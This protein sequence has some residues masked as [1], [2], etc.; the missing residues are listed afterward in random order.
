[1]RLTGGVLPADLDLVAWV[2]AEE[3][4]AEL[5]AGGDGL[6]A[7]RGD[8]VAVCKARRRGRLAA[9]DVGDRHAGA[10][11]AAVREAAEVSEAASRPVVG[12]DLDAEEGRGADVGG[13]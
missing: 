11:G 12:G 10:R 8:H 5:R 4:S 7:E 9:H 3:Q 13:G 6:A 1:M 2:V